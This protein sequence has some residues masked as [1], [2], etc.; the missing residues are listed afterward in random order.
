MGTRSDSKAS[1]SGTPLSTPRK[2]VAGLCAEHRTG[3]IARQRLLTLLNGGT[4]SLQRGTRDEDCYGRKLHIVERNHR[5]LGEML[6][7]DGLA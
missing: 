4:L 1:I 6:V 5:S 3:D 2:S 7:E